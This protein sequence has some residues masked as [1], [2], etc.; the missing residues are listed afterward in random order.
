MDDMNK[1]WYVYILANK[2]N[3]TLYVGVTND[4]LRRVYEH[5]Q[6]LNDWFTKKYSIKKLV[7]YEECPSIESAILR[8]KQLKWWNREKKVGLIVSINPERKDLYEWIVE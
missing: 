2:E 3:G 8:E 5:K 1:T 4:L 7:Y 6:W